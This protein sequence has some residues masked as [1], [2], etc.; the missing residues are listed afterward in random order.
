MKIQEC[1]DATHWQLDTP[2]LDLSKEISGAYEGDLLSWV[3]GRGNEGDAWITVQVHINV[4]AVAVLREFSCVIIAD[5]A[6]VTE[7]FIQKAAEE[8]LVIIES[9]L[10][11]YE[12][13]VAL[14]QLGI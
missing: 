7:E 11:S 8:K 13:A 14:H 5:N 3:M 12:T 2:Q 1:I 10:P 4:L 9:G 6:A